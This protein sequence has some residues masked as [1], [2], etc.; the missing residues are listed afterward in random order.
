MDLKQLR[1][2]LTIC[3]EGQITAAAKKLHMAQPPLSQQLKALEEELGVM[4]V[5]R[6]NRNIL[7]TEAGELLK[8]KATHI[9]QACEDMKLEIRDGSRGI[10]LTLRIGIVPSSHA[11]FLHH[12]I[13]SFHQE[14]PNTSFDMKEGNTFQVMEMLEKGVI[15]IGVVR[16]PFPQNRFCI[17]KIMREPM[18]AVVLKNH[19]PFAKTQLQV[20]DF[21]GHSIIYYERYEKLLNEI[22]I[23][24]GFLPDILCRNQDARTTIAWASAGL[25][26]GIVPQSA[27]IMCDKKDLDILEIMDERLYTDIVIITIKE[28]YL[29]DTATAFLNYYK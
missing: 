6:G 4:L 14:Y 22:F 24:N 9:L 21:I 29:S 26:I 8:E 28:R 18:V 27:T 12:G 3:E 5:K 25:G 7:L 1:Y 15:E 20:K 23:E 11:V 19:N 10:K 17:Q 13:Q 16:T 2:F